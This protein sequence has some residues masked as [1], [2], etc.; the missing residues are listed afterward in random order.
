MAAP[1][2]GPQDLVARITRLERRQRMLTPV[3][4]LTI[5]GILA[6]LAAFAPPSPGVVQAQRVELV[7]PKG[8]VLAAWSA[9]SSGVLLTLLD[10][11]GRTAASYRLNDDPRITVLDG[12]GREV[13]GLG[14]PRV[15]HL[16]E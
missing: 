11:N 5:A 9:D 10:R 16:S 15:H 3:A 12:N 2:V 1:R 13:A 6:A 8:E 7:S 4:A 14:V